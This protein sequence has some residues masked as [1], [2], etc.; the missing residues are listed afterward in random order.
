LQYNLA[1][2]YELKCRIISC[3]PQCHTDQ[4]R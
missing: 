3:D 2:E 4:W 1:L